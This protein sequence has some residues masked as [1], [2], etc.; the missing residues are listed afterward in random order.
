MKPRSSAEKILT[1]R[2]IDLDWKWTDVCRI[3]GLSASMVSMVVKGY[4]TSVR[5]RKLVCKSL[6]LKVDE[7][8]D[9]QKK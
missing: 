3:T 2:L 9:E 8:F 4:R 5:S 7:V 1:Y 6:G